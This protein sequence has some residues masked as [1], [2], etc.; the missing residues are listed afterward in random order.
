MVLTIFIIKEAVNNGYKITKD[1]VPYR[2]NTELELNIELNYPTIT[3]Q[4]IYSDTGTYNLSARKLAAYCFYGDKTFKK[5]TSIKHLD[6]NPYNLSKANLVLDHST[7]VAP[8]IHRTKRS[9]A[10]SI[11]RAAQGIIPANAKL[12]QETRDAIIK[13]RELK[14][15]YSAIGLKFNVHKS[16]IHNLLTKR[17]YCE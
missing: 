17:T 4:T 15:S 10:A 12:D 13:L 9:K 7:P 16:T 3:I 5:G 6:G 14:Y 1:G 8:E 2:F 11:A